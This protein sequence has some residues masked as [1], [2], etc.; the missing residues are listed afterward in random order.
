MQKLLLGTDGIA[1]E[2]LKRVEETLRLRNGEL[3]TRLSPVELE[4][5][6]SATRYAQEIFA[7]T[8]IR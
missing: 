5:L 2:I 6:A 1:I 4:E 8:A 3:D 7:D